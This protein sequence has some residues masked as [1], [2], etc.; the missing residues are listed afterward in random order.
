MS[1]PRAGHV[2][3]SLL[4]PGKRSRYAQLTGGNKGGSN[5]SSLGVGHVRQTPMEPGLETGYV[6]KILVSWIEEGFQ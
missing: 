3:H 6:G 1:G 2:Q 5:M 4:E